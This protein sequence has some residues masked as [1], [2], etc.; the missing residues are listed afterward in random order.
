MFQKDVVFYYW[1]ILG[2]TKTIQLIEK[3][4]AIVFLCNQTYNFH[5]LIKQTQILKNHRR[6]SLNDKQ[7][8]EHKNAYWTHLSSTVHKY[9][10]MCNFV[11]LGEIWLKGTQYSPVHSLKKVEHKLKYT[12]ISLV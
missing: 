10:C 9:I 1:C 6:D 4:C 8:V 7:L 11:I 2:H 3:R 5:Q 12:V